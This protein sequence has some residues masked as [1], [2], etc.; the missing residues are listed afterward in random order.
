MPQLRPIYSTDMCD[1]IAFNLPKTAR[2]IAANAL[3]EHRHP[4]MF[5]LNGKAIYIPTMQQVNDVNNDPRCRFIQ[6]AWANEARITQLRSGIYDKVYPAIYKIQATIES[7]HDTKA[8][9]VAPAALTE[10][11]T[12]LAKLSGNIR[13]ITDYL[14]KILDQLVIIEEKLINCVISMMNNGVI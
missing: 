4:V 12:K 8:A 3:P 13:N 6:D 1:I 10:V 5:E 11:K 14:A 9:K 7:A 2:N